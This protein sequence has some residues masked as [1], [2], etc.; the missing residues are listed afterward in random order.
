MGQVRAGG[1]RQDLLDDRGH[2]SLVVAVPAVKA[3]GSGDPKSGKKRAL[4]Q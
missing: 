1:V 3:T 2:H 4:A